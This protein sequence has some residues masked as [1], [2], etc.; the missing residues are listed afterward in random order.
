MTTRDPAT[1]DRHGGVLAS[2]GRG[3]LE[4]WRE[5]GRILRLGAQSLRTLPRLEAALAVRQLFELGNRSLVFVVVVLGFTG[6]ILVIQ[7][8]L[9]ARRIIGDLSLIGP[10][11][12][13]L[14][15]REF[16]PT[17][18][19]LM[20]AARY[21]AGVA[22]ELG[23][24]RVTEQVDA[25]QMA[26]EEPAAF[27]VAPRLVAG[28]LGTPALV[29][30]GTAAAFAA[31]GLAAYHGFGVSHAA[32]YRLTL[33]GMADVVV[34]GVKALCFGLA[35]PVVA[36]HAGLS[37]RGGAA[38]VGRA[39]TRAVIGASLAVLALDLVVGAIAQLW[40]GPMAP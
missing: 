21:G 36:S 15:V 11:F 2:I 16:G 10:T 30:A 23:A 34:G 31:G 38:G 39:T 26:G 5:V 13:Q 25:L 27:L 33:V 37:A 9:Q 8:S 3:P 35:I 18:V 28:L 32:Y 12:L 19:A 6:A 17:I 40:L 22:A 29:I 14:L 4:L 7:A 20:I 24:M 1:R